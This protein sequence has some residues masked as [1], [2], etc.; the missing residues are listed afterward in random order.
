[1]FVGDVDGDIARALVVL[2]VE[3]SSTAIGQQA[4]SGFSI[5]LDLKRVDGEW[6]VDRQ[7]YAPQPDIAGGAADGAAT[8][9]TV[10]T[11]P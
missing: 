8:S 2:D 7:R 9:T 3:L 6:R 1:M 10:S 5:V 4:L 11:P